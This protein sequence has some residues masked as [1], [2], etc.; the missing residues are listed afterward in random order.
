MSLLA[1]WLWMY[2]KEENSLWREVFNIKY[3]SL[4]DGAP[5][6]STPAME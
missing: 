6:P 1:K 4:A 2:A 5:T 3:G